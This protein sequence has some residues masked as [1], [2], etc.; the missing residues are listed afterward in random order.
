MEINNETDEPILINETEDIKDSLVIEPHLKRSRFPFVWNTTYEPKDNLYFQLNNSWNSFSF[1]KLEKRIITTINKDSGQKRYYKFKLYRKNKG[2]TRQLKLVEIPEDKAMENKFFDKIFFLKSKRP[3]SSSYVVH[4]N[5]IGMSII[6]NTPK[7]LFYI[8]FYDLKIKYISNF[9]K[10]DFGTKTQTT[11]NIELYMKNFQIDYCL[12]DSIKNIIF[13]SNQMTPTKEA[14]LEA[15]GER[16]VIEEFVP[17]LSMLVTRQNFKNDKKNESISFYRQIDL[18]IQEFNIKV[19]Q[20]VVTCLLELINEIMGFFDYST[21]LDDIKKEKEEVEK[22]LETKIEVPLE[23][24]LKENEDLERMT[25]N[26]LMLGCLKFNVTLRLDLSELNLL[27]MPKSIKRILGSVGNTLTRI[28]DS[29]L[30]FNEK[31]FTNIYK[32]SNENYVG[33]Y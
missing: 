22:I 3:S 24:L 8:S 12:N 20:Y 30:K 6:N 17:F 7:E 18:V 28:T 23:K 26:I 5:G 15:N 1:S 11:E 10:T 32:N 19:E 25:I 14:E 16:N 31:I 4:L 2:M 21:K 9:L 29:K 13:P 33:T 27:S